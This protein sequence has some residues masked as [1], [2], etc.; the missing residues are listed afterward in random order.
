[1]FIV[2]WWWIVLFSGTDILTFFLSFLVLKLCVCVCVCVCVCERERERERER[3]L[4]VDFGI[5]VMSS[6][7]MYCC[8]LKVQWCVI[9][10]KFIWWEKGWGRGCMLVE[11]IILRTTLCNSMM[12]QQWNYYFLDKRIFALSIMASTLVHVLHCTYMF[13]SICP[14]RFNIYHHSLLKVV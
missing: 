9:V 7:L 10:S 12:H 1:M 14:F 3:V 8:Y 13:V 5:S 2:K 6:S 11:Y 4:K